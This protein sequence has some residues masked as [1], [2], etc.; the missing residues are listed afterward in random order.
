MVC[1]GSHQYTP[2]MLAYVPAPWILIMGYRIDPDP[3][4]Q[5]ESCFLN[6]VNQGFNVLTCGIV[7]KHGNLDTPFLIQTD[8]CPK[9]G[10][11]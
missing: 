3:P 7:P 1:H 5:S 11:P 4:S 10:F 8:G 2:V 9:T 6:E